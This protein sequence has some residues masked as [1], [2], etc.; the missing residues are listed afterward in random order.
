[1]PSSISSSN[2]KLRLPRLFFATPSEIVALEYE[3]PIPR[4]PWRGLTVVVVL[5]VLAATAAWELYVRSKGYGRTLNDNE[6]LWVQV[7]RNVTPES[8]VI[9]G[10]SRPLF[11]LDLD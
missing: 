9:V 2:R 3:R 5:I 6:D 4:L 10:D 11:D 8:I 7:R 1:M